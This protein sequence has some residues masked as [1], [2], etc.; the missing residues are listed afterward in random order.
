MTIYKTYK[1]SCGC[2]QL[3]AKFYGRIFPTEPWLVH[4]I[5]TSEHFTGN[6]LEIGKILYKTFSKQRQQK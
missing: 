4:E 5:T 6:H 2:E 1:T 3:R